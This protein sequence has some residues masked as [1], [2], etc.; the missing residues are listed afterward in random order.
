MMSQP[1]AGQW[2]GY[3]EDQFS[4]VEALT[5]DLRSSLLVRLYRTDYGWDQLERWSD[6]CPDVEIEEGYT[7]IRDLLLHTRVVLCTYNATTFLESF[8]MDIPTIMFWNPEHWELRQD[9]VLAFELLEDA[10][11]LFRRPADAA[12]KLS[13][14]WDDVDGWWTSA[15]VRSARQQFCELYNWTSGDLVERVADALRR[16]VSAPPRP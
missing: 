16:V 11:L 12:R 2:L 1:H 8:A 6:R 3:L 15:P 5:G 4:F 13:E 10:G 14:V 7:P 9:A